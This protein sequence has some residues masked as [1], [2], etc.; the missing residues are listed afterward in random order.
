VTTVKAGTLRT[1]AASLLGSW[2]YD[3]PDAQFLSDSLVDAN[4]RGVDSHGVMRLP[5]YAARIERHLIDPLARPIV[6]T[7]GAVVSVDANRAAGQIAARA[8]VEQ[9]TASSAQFGVATAVIHGSA[10]FGA[11]GYYARLLAGRGQVAFVVS[12]SEP[13]VVPFGGR[14]ALLGTN[15]L[16][17]AA[18]TAD[19]PLSLDMAT[20]TTAMGKVMVALSRHEQIPDDWGVDK[21]GQ[22]T[23]DPAEVVALLP[24]G[25]P[26]GYGLGMLVEVLGG[27][28]S[29]A[30]IAGNLGNMYTDFDRPQN[31]GHWMLALNIEAFMPLAEFNDR[32]AGLVGMVRA[33]QPRDEARPV[34][35]PGEPEE[36]TNAARERDGIPIPDDTAEELSKLGEHY[37]VA[38][39]PGAA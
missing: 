39:F 21:D 32:M 20:S 15:P 31:V 9:L 13:I 33:T 11:A 23:T 8:A 30:A 7:T 19:L 12:N 25:G 29:G 36:F 27:V 16:A 35:V 24:V 37:K 18:P 10:H 2:G 4:L 17:F 28:L 14:A 1:W 22:P 6:T 5:A 34:L 3:A 26:K 38:P